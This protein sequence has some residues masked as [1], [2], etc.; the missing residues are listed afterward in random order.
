MVSVALA[1]AATLLAGAAIFAVVFAAYL[2]LR[3]VKGWE[4][5]TASFTWNPP[6]PREPATEEAAE[7]QRH[8]LDAQLIS[9]IH[10]S[11]GYDREV[12]EMW[13]AEKREEGWEEGDIDAFL[14][15]RPP[16]ELS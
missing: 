16:I 15:S 13:K 3:L 8:A 10:A 6:P 11:R 1:A 5:R 14:A 4:A 7:A 2:G 12:V 9:F